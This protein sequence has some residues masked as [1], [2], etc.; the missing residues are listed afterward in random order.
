MNQTASR[1][2]AVGVVVGQPEAVGE[3][4]R[5][6]SAGHHEHGQLEQAE[7]ADPEDLA[8][9]QVARADRRED[10]L[11]DPALLL[12]DDARQ[13]REAEAEDADEDQHGADVGEQEARA[14]RP[15]SAG[16]ATSTAGACWAARNSAGETS[17]SASRPCVRSP[18]T[19][20]VTSW[21]TNWSRLLVEADG[22]P[23]RTGRP[24][25]RRR[26][27]RLRPSS[28]FCGGRLVGEGHDLD[29]AVELRQ[30]GRRR[31]RRREPG[32]FRLR[33]RRSAS[34]LRRRTGP[35]AG[36]TTRPRAAS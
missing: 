11:D 15:R 19:A 5:R 8:H 33:R 16:R 21:V 35:P 12:L 30:G 23:A 31:E 3:R 7:D 22:L 18:T 2:I 26:P 24:A 9:Q 13:D 27:R 25:R 10:D 20:A 14:R 6:R 28:A 4:A 36:R 29:L 34:P 1:G 32:R 17:A